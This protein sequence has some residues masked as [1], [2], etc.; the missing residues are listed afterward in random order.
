V[1]KNASTTQLELKGMKTTKYADDAPLTHYHNTILQSLGDIEDQIKAIETPE[2]E[3]AS[4]FDSLTTGLNTI[5]NN[6]NASNIND[7]LANVLQELQNLQKLVEELYYDLER[8]NAL[9]T[10]NELDRIVFLE[11][12]FLKGGDFR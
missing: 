3:I 12:N 5:L 2:A 6:T 8:I 9:A 1:V 4:G 7:Q 11:V 10:L